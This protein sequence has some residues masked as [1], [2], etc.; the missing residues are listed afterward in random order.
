MLASESCVH[1]REQEGAQIVSSINPRLRSL[2]GGTAREERWTLAISKAGQWI[3]GRLAR[4]SQAKTLEEMRMG[5]ATASLFCEWRPLPAAPPVPSGPLPASLRSSCQT[6]IEAHS[7]P[8][9]AA[10]T[11]FRRSSFPE[12]RLG[13]PCEGS[14]AQNRCESTAKMQRRS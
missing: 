1:R 9:A 11:S 13:K 14:V 2:G 12:C 10:C 4:G 5:A 8:Q 6:L 7:T 3:P